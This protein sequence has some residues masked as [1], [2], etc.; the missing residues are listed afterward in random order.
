MKFISWKIEDEII[1]G[2]RKVY[3]IEG[4]N[5]LYKNS[6][7]QLIDLRPAEGKPSVTSF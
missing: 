1:D 5:G 3:A 7:G 2:K 4:Y 6:D